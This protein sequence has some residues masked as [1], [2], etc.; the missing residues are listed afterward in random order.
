MISVPIVKSR[1]PNPSASKLKPVQE[2]LPTQSSI[3]TESQ[4]KSFIMQNAQINH[5]NRYPSSSELINIHL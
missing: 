5:T 3:M 2:H 4:N 1:V